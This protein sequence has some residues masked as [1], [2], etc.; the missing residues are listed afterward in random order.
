[1]LASDRSEGG[2]E[3]GGG[4]GYLDPCLQFVGGK[5]PGIADHEIEPSEIQI[6][7]F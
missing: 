3:S 2:S 7:R 1:L 5:K 6:A 4:V